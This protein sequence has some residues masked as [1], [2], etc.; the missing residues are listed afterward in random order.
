MKPSDADDLLERLTAALK[1]GAT[2]TLSGEKV[3]GRS[4]E[5]WPMVA[6]IGTSKTP[7]VGHTAVELIQMTLS[8]LRA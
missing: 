2:I 6:T 4:G 5:V 8:R 3:T 7:C 1:K